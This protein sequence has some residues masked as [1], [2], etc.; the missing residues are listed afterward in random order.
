M[1]DVSGD[2]VTIGRESFDQ[3]FAALRS[4]GYDIIGPRVRDEAIVYDHIASSADLPIGWQDELAPGRYR[5]HQTGQPTLFDY[6]VG[7]TSWKKFLFPPKRQLWKGTRDG[8]SF[9]VQVTEEEPKSLAFLGVR[10]CEVA[11]IRVQDK[12]FRDGTYQDQHY[13]AQRQNILIIAVNCVRAGGTCFCVSMNTGPAVQQG[14]DLAITELFSEQKHEFL[15]AAGTETGREILTDMSAVKLASKESQAE[16]ARGIALAA[17]QM[18]RKLETEGIKDLLYRNAESPL[19]DDVAQ[20]CLSCANCTMVCPTC[21]CSSVEEVN[22]LTG[23]HTERWQRWDSCFTMD[24]SY[25]HG[26]SVRATTKSRYRQWLTHKFASWI[27]QFGE[28]G[29]VGCGKCISWCPVGIDVTAEVAALRVADKTARDS[30]DPSKEG[31]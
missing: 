22:D 8:A 5:I 4:R 9:T 7:P 20:R 28:S 23:D 10:S 6:N 30:S 3:L 25:L 16:A 11:G 18:G 27:D 24:H 19:W 29:C 15:I 13:A 1:S 21:F 31:T 17:S 14:Y 12:V 2:N 26:G